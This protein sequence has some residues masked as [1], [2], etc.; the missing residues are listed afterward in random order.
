MVS[1]EL[2]GED[3]VLA[4]IGAIYDVALDAQLW[5]DV[6]NRIGDAVGSPQFMFGFYD[7][8]T[9]MSEI[10]ASRFD[11]DVVRSCVELGPYNPLPD[12]SAA[13]PPGKVFTISDF[14]TPDEF[15]NTT[16]YRE[17]WR[18]A[19]L[20]LEPLTT[21]LLVDGGAAAIFTSNRAADRSPPDSG[22]KRL[23]AALAQH[24]VR[25]VALQR[26]LH[27]L[28]VANETA[29]TA[30]DNLQQG[31]VLVDAE[32]RPLFVNRV[33]QALLDAQDGLRL[34]TG[35]LFA[36][37]AD[38]GRTLRGIIAACAAEASTTTG[39]GGEVT[40]R[41]ASGRRPL[42]ILVMPAR[43]ES[44]VAAMS[45]TIARRPVAIVLISD[46]DKEIRARIESL[47]ERFG[48][49]PAEAILALEIV[50]G[51]GRQAT[52]DRLGISVGTARSHLSKIFNKTGVTR[53]AE[54]V[55][56]LLQQ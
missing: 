56:L 41:R 51:D 19:G 46:P 18:P 5:P 20:S 17:W 13:E 34:E 15:R 30:L 35:A 33:A 32:A 44:A 28:S 14:L 36:S 22:Q 7:A 38:D 47:R 10:H 24:L 23:F 45:W 39:T 42:E 4:L 54:L 52:A 6:L 8:A 31:F 37:D 1:G 11:P 29:V 40:L 2:S 21:N 55:R 53:Q 43:Q 3:K 50:K 25:A 12:L 9:G 27:Q 16:F 26:R 49:T 48:F